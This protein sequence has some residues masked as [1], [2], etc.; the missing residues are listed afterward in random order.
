MW[1]IK[2]LVGKVIR[3]MDSLLSTFKI[4]FNFFD[5]TTIAGMTLTTWIVILIVISAIGLFVRGNK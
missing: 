4:V 2:F 1:F 5:S 3:K